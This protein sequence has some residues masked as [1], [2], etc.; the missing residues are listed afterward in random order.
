MPDLLSG[1][2]GTLGGA[3]HRAA[4][5]FPDRGIAVFDSRGRKADR[6]PYAALDAAARM[7]AAR[8]A[9]LR[10]AER[11]PVLIALPT[12]WEWIETWFGVLL[13]GAWPVAA[14]AVGALASAGVQ[15]E[16][17]DTVRRDIGARRVVSS[18]GFR[19]RAR[20]HGLG[21]LAE[22]TITPAEI[23]AVTPQRAFAAPP[24][25]PGD[26]AFLQLTS[27]STGLPRAVMIPH[28]AAIHNPMASAEAIG[29]P[30]GE[31][32]HHWA[33]AMVSWLPLYHDMGLVGCLLL[34][35]LA[36]LD[37]WLLRPR[38]F[39]ARPRL[40]LEQLGSHGTAFVPAPNFA[41]QLC[42]ERLG[43]RALDG[44][45]LSLW[46][47]ALTGAEMIRPETT[48]AFQATFASCGFTPAAFRPCYGLAEATLTVS[49]DRRG[50]GVRTRRAPPA[51]DAGPG[52]TEAVSTGEP[53][54]DTQVGIAALDGTALPEDRIG[55]VRVK[56]PGQFLGY[57]NH[58]EERAASLSGGWFAT[59]DLGFVH[60][61]ELYLTGRTKDVIIVRGETRMPH[62]IEWVADGVTGGGGLLR[63]AAFSVA[64]GAR[65]EQVVVVVESGLREPQRLRELDRE[66]R[67]R[68][69]RDLGLPLADLA[70]VRRGRIPRTSSG[71]TQR[72]QLRR[73]YLEGRLER[74]EA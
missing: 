12:S 7:N 24:A 17:I 64:R 62:E 68:I 44:L 33:D 46:K 69:G 34:P 42:V 18:D 26:T 30:H 47:A 29:A 13:R 27:G 53:I 59:G 23:A 54:R 6:R 72:Q 5:D 11:E 22:R 71:K 25:D 43:A 66:I 8:F 32:V 74:L 67:V 41:Y 58:P 60:A 73:T 39:L 14:P 4:R 63:S 31:P 49:L 55:E 38:T 9:A 70:F 2:P 1:L 37:T 61:G 19:R 10:I 52:L 65:G 51:A 3:L 35:I 15:L 36:G 45:D 28:R 40:W 48:E 50:E 56:G 57:H 21:E 16:K 20:E